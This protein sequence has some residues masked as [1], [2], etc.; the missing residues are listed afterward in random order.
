MA[1]GGRPARKGRAHE[2][3]L[4]T[5]YRRDDLRGSLGR[6]A[7]DRAVPVEAQT[8]RRRSVRHRVLRSSRV[9]DLFGLAREEEA[10]RGVAQ[11]ALRGRRIGWGSKSF[12]RNG[13]C[14]AR[15]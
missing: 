11:P 9:D 1:S 12:G 8:A 3:Q 5:R 14:S 6:F 7:R 2:P 15:S 13:R 4:G 10:R